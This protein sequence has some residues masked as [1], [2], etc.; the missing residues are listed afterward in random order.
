MKNMKK[1]LIAAFFVLCCASAAVSAVVGESNFGSFRYPAFEVPAPVP[2]EVKTLESAR[3]Y[4]LEVEAYIKQAE[5]YAE[6]VRSDIDR[7]NGEIG[8]A[9]DKVN[10]VTSAFNEWAAA[11]N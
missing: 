11:S 9:A 6:A 3:Q 2:P 1:G 8:R 10:E 7:I 4:R 5:A